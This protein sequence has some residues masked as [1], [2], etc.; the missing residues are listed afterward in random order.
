MK[1]YEMIFV[2]KNELAEDQ[3]NAIATS[4]SEFLKSNGAE[5]K[6]EHYFGVRSLAYEI[7][8]NKKGHYYL[9]HF[10]V[11]Q[12]K[13]AELDHMVRL[14]EDVIRHIVVNIEES[15]PDEVL[16]MLTIKDRDYESSDDAM[17]DEIAETV[18]S[19]DAGYRQ[20]ATLAADEVE[21]EV[22]E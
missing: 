13:I 1:L 18:P 7:Q 16:A 22:K 19:A 21:D 5:I 2:A 8:K 20:K 3:V 12:D 11:D 17:M 10:E 9:M 4:F 6:F 14:N 15:N